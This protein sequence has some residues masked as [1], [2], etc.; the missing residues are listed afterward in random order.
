ML[1]FATALEQA[2]LGKFD[3]PTFNV[4]S[5]PTLPNTAS[6]VTPLPLQT[7]LPPDVAQQGLTPIVPEDRA[8]STS[9]AP[10]ILQQKPLPIDRKAVLARVREQ[11]SY[12]FPTY[13]NPLLA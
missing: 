8:T 13:L 3:R 12:S 9:R 11:E 1:D 6:E 4:H 10:L 2:A 7:A 5:A